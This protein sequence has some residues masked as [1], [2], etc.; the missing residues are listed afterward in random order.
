LAVGSKERAEVHNA[1]DRTYLKLRNL[2]VRGALAP[3]SSLIER[4]MAEVVG[5]SRSTVRSALHRLALE[6]H[7]VV[8]SIGDRYSRFSVAPLTI[9]EMREWYFIFGALD[10]IAARGAAAL[11]AEQR[12][13]LAER[14]RTLAGA[15]LEAGRGDDPHFAKVQE[16]DTALHDSY[17]HLGG[18]PRLLREHQALRPHVDRYGIVYATALIRKLPTQIF[19]EHCA[20][21]DAIE[22]GDAEA[23]ERAAVT[24]WRNATDRFEAVMSGWGERGNWETIGVEGEEGGGGSGERVDASTPRRGDSVAD[25]Q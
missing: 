11:P 5:A 20:I 13:P 21:A 17:V 22:A 10:G 24:N 18:G 6:G 16:L 1:V 14:V 19:Q 25:T 15:H 12:R 8:S 23:A 2:I 4:Q 7:V 9:G 3:G